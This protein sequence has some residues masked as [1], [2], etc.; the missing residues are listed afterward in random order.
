MNIS[1][2]LVHKSNILKSFQG[3]QNC[4]RGGGGGGGG[5][6]N[7]PPLPHT[8]TKNNNNLL[9]LTLALSSQRDDS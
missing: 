4:F 6:G 3:V 8:H 9:A 7:I 5:G 2:V 1:G